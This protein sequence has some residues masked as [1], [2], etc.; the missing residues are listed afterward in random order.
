MSPNDAP[1]RHFAQPALGA[2]LRVRY[3]FIERQATDSLQVCTAGDFPSSGIHTMSA[4]GAIRP[5]SAAVPSYR[6]GLGFL[7][8]LPRNNPTLIKESSV[9]LDCEQSFFTLLRQGGVLLLDKS[10]GSANRIPG[11]DVPDEWNGSEEPS[12]TQRVP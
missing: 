11:R 9:R 4:P 8:L 7:L 1:G 6:A 2:L 3:E 10:A 5:F 12:E